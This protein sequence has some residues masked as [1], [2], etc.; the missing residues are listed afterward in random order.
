M[1]LFDISVSVLIGLITGC[2]SG[3]ITGILI[4]KYYRSKDEKIERAQ[5][6]FK[7]FSE[8]LTYLENIMTEL[9]LIDKAQ[10][11]D[12]NELERLLKNKLVRHEILPMVT[13]MDD[14]TVLT[15]ILTTLM[16]MEKSCENRDVNIQEFKNKIIQINFIL[17]KYKSKV[18]CKSTD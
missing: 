5:K 17:M 7:A 9:E 15:Q 8:L 4:T 3:W 10:E 2:I 12:Y 1:N 11:K 18:L 6:E 13:M 16:S 14:G